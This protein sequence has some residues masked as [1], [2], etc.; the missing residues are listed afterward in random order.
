M[1]WSQQSGSGR[2]APADLVPGSSLGF[3]SHLTFIP[4]QTLARMKPPFVPAAG[5]NAQGKS[6]GAR[7]SALL[8]SRLL[9]Q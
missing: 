1:A 7:N 4:G 8:S 5:I 6:E 9:I 2:S 3:P